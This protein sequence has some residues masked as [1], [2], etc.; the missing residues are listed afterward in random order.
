MK[1]KQKKN[2]VVIKFK[3]ASALQTDGKSLD[4]FEIGYQ[5]PGTE[6][7]TYQKAGAEISGNNVL[8]KTSGTYKPVAVRYAWMLAGDANL[9]DREGL[10]AFPFRKNIK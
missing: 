3:T 6:S 9:F 4:G 5:M 7:I 10:P 8:L 1:V 2:L